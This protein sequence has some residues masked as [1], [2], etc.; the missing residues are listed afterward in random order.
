MLPLDQLDLTSAARGGAPPEYW[1]LARTPVVTG[2]D[3]RDARPQQNSQ[4]GG[5]E[6][7]FRADPG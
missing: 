7:Q 4:N 5:W 1:I 3:L 6:T 2:R